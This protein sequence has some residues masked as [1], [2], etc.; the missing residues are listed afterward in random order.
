MLPTCK[1]AAINN[2]TM[3]VTSFTPFLIT[4]EGKFVMTKRIIQN[5]SRFPR[6]VPKDIQKEI[7]KIYLEGKSTEKAGVIFG[8]SGVCVGAILKKNNI[9]RRARAL[10]RDSEIIPLYLS[11]IDAPQ[12]EEQ[13]GVSTSHVYDVLRRH[14]IKTRDNISKIDR[15]FSKEQKAEIVSLYKGGFCAK[16]IAEKMNLA[17]WSV[18]R[19]LNKNGIKLRSSAD[20][21]GELANGWKGGLRDDVEYQRI[22]RNKNNKIRRD[23]DPVYKLKCS[24]LNRI[25]AAFKVHGY[26]K[27]SRTHFLLGASY[28]VVAKHIESQ[29]VDGMDW[30]NHG[31]GHGFWNFDHR[32]PLATAQTE[33]ELL[34]LFHFSNI[35]P[36]WW[37]ENISKGS[38]HEGKRN[39]RRR[40]L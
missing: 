31:K 12:I 20:R 35:Q 14:K 26:K 13:L 19:F 33:E 1:K 24:L 8:I 3:E 6:G 32:I 28:E 4:N 9:P 22:K 27:Q 18:G 7:I 15:H 37:I 36:M 10:K 11:G 16:E 17:S 23:T 2:E 38:L 29:F 5:K 30:Q 25:N 34:K 21:V 40:V 39:H